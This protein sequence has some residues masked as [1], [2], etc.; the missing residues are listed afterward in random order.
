MSIIDSDV[1]DIRERIAR[2][3]ER[4]I[5]LCSML[6]KSLSGYGDLVNRVSALEK[7]KAHFFLAAALIGTA[8]SMS[9]ELIKARYFSKG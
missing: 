4:Q 8:V 9:W 5:S 7:L 2:M 1:S 6:E 3:E